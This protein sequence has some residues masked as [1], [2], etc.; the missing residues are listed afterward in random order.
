M[1][2]NGRQSVLCV[3]C[4]CVCVSL[5]LNNLTTALLLA[6]SERYTFKSTALP[7]YRPTAD[8]LPMRVS[9]SVCVGLALPCATGVCACVVQLVI[10]ARDAS[11]RLRLQP[12]PPYNTAIGNISAS[13]T[14]SDD[15]QCQSH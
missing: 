9:L 5:C 7:S 11:I 3:L 12:L 6:T 14:G 1:N 13:S 2:E 15:G 4:V 8:A 10:A